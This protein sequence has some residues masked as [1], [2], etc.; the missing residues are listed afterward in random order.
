[1]SD[2][3]TQQTLPEPDTADSVAADVDMPELRLP[4]HHLFDQMI[5]WG[6]DSVPSPPSVNS[7]NDNAISLKVMGIMGWS[8]EGT[9][10]F[11]AGVRQDVKDTN[12]HAYLPINVVYGRKL[13]GPRLLLILYKRALLIKYFCS[14]GGS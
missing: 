4:H 9:Q 7:E 8:A 6:T 12:I 2:D 3:N 5:S 14:R 11:L 10:V 1:M 13:G